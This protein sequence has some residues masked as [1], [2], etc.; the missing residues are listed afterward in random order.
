MYIYHPQLK[1]GVGEEAWGGEKIIEGKNKLYLRKVLKNPKQQEK[2]RKHLLWQV[3]R[4]STVSGK[5]WKKNLG[6]N[7]SGL[8][9][10][11]AGANAT[12]SY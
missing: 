8:W 1:F 7:D 11:Q 6:Q 3:C 12:G 10:P 2:C 9:M 4:A 5:C